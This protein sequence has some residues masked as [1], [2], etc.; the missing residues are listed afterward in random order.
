MQLGDQAPT[1]HCQVDCLLNLATQ[2][3]Q[4]DQAPSFHCQVSDCKHDMR[5]FLDEK[6]PALGGRQLLPEL[7]HHLFSECMDV[8]TR[9]LAHADREIRQV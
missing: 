4:V 3:L 7:R 8:E 2:A 5:N 6:Q 9:N 1:F